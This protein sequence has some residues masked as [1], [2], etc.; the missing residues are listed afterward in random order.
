MSTKSLAPSA[1]VVTDRDP[2]GIKFMSIVAAA[3]NKAGLPEDEAQHVNDTPGLAG[4]IASFIEENRR[5]NKY[6]DEEVLS[7]YG[8]LSGYSKPKGL[9]Q[10][11]ND[12]RVLFSGLGFANLDLQEQIEDG[13]VALPTGAEGWFAIPNWMKNPEIFGKTYSEVVQTVLN[14]IKK[15]RQGKFFNYREGQVIEKQLRQSA[16]SQ[17]FWQDLATAQDNPDILIIAAQ[18]GIRHRGRSDRRALEVIA[19]TPGEFGLGAF[20]V[21][22]MILTHP[23]RLMNYDDL[24]ID[25]SGDEFDDPSSDVRFAHAPFFHFNGYR[26]KFGAGYVDDAREHY[27]AASGFVSQ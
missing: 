4:L 15:A 18:F 17:K 7:T 19:G 21:G 20:A 2:K 9:I 26:V 16:K 23:E 14:A 8:Y 12:L 25:C 6:K 27:G 5:T 13:K 3:Y 22:I 10:Q 1:T 24:W 11:T